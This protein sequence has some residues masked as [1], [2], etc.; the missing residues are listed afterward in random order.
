MNSTDSIYEISIYLKG[1]NLNPEDVT[2]QIGTC[3]TSSQKKGDKSSTPTGAMVEKKTGLWSLSVASSEGTSGLLGQ[4]VTRLTKNKSSLAE[5]PNVEEA[6]IDVFVAV[7]VDDS[8]G[9]KAE[10]HFDEK[11]ITALCELRLPVYF[12]VSLIN[13]E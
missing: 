5:L 8:G 7:Y 9:E 6:Y 10:F 2:N 13:R 11:C 1:V 12:S 3:P 4:L